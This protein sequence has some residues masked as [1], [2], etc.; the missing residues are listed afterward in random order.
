MPSGGGIRSAA[1][2]LGIIQCLASHKAVSKRNGNATERLLEQ[3]EYLSTVSGGGYTGSWLSAWLYQARANPQ[4][5]RAQGVLAQ[6]NNR[7]GDHHEVEP[8][9][10]LRRNSHYLAPRFSALSPDIW[11]DIAA[12]ARNLLLNWFLFIPPML[13]VVLLTKA[14]GFTFA[15]ASR[16]A[17]G[18]GWSAVVTVISIL[19]VL[20]ALVFAVANRP[21][22]GLVNLNQAKFLSFDLLPFVLGAICLVFVLVT[23]DDQTEFS[24]AASRLALWVKG[25][26]SL[27]VGYLSYLVGAGL[28]L[29]LYLASWLIA[30]PGGEEPTGTA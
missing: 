16:T 11:S 28:G 13:L 14:A 30:S 27:D 17:I 19:L 24:Q 9:T 25:L 10:N 2:A 8:I 4:G 23:P 15:D 6:L 20:G 1:F 18:S 29:G 12:I 21:T 5:Q 7:I 26:G 3:F 22:R